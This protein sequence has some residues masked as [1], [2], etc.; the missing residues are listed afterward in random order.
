MGKRK[1]AADIPA[2]NGSQ[3]IG[4]VARGDEGRSRT[5][6]STRGGVQDTFD[7]GEIPYGE[8]EK[9]DG[10]TE[11]ERELVKVLC[12]LDN[13]DLRM[14]VESFENGKVDEWIRANGDFIQLC[15]DRERE[16]RLTP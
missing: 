12:S 6:I 11:G 2:A 16:E 4:L 14:V 15:R 5:A 8:N 1:R 9:A 7:F 3:G 10:L 13:D